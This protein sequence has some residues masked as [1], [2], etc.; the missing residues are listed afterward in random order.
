MNIFDYGKM[1]SDVSFIKKIV[2]FVLNLVEGAM[3]L[4][5]RNTTSVIMIIFSIIYSV[6]YK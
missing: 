1:S 2:D 4:S 5:V 6:K 3:A